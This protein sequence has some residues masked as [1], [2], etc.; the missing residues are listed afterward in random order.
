MDNKNRRSFLKLFSISAFGTMILSQI[1]F[2]K[3]RVKSNLVNQSPKVKIH[4]M[5]VKREKG[6]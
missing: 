4:S 2:A 5:A 1:P 6:N 3:N